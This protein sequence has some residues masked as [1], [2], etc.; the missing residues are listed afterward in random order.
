MFIL[1]TLFSTR[2]LWHWQ[3]KFL[4]QT[5][6][7]VDVDH[8]LYSH[9]LNFWFRNESPWGEIRCQSLLAVKGAEL[10]NLESPRVRKKTDKQKTFTYAISEVSFQGIWTVSS[11]SIQNGLGV[12]CLTGLFIVLA[13]RLTWYLHDCKLLGKYNYWRGDFLF[14]FKNWVHSP[15]K[16]FKINS[17]IWTQARKWV[18]NFDVTEAPYCAESARNTNRNWKKK[19]DI[20]SFCNILCQFST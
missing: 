17:E 16:K 7:T 19:S 5:R 20:F 2:F 3:G 8:F 1:S 9:D 13:D 4:S 14:S 15:D 6:A 12:L 10:P 11:Y 18:E